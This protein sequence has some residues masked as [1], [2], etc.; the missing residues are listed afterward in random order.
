MN[1]NNIKTIPAFLH[2]GTLDMGLTDGAIEFTVE[3]INKEIK[4]DQFGDEVLALINQGSNISF[5]AIFKEVTKEMLN[6]IYAQGGLA[7]VYNDGACTG[8]TSDG[9]EKT[10]AECTL[11]SGTWTPNVNSVLGFGS[12]KVGTNLASNAKIIK[13]V[14]KA[15]SEVDKSLVFWKAYPVPGGINYSGADEATLEIEF[16]VIEDT[17]KP[18]EI[19]KGYLGNPTDIPNFVA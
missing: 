19:S 4:A 16:K 14:P 3:G 8:G 11:Q 18:T 5:K 17:T 7:T 2:Y 9:S 6:E 10:E 15:T 1:I 13:L 12:A